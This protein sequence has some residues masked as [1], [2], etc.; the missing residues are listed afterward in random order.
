MNFTSIKITI[1]IEEFF[2]KKDARWLLYASFTHG[3]PQLQHEGR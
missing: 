1:N 2:F 3:K